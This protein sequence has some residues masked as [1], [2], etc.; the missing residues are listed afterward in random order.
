MRHASFHGDMD[1]LIAGLKVSLNQDE[2]A[3]PAS[4]PLTP[5]TTRNAI[6]TWPAFWLISDVSR[7]GRLGWPPEIDFFEFVNNVDQTNLGGN[8]GIIALKPWHGFGGHLLPAR[9][10]IP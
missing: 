7:T 3:P 8:N 10:A 4:D 2:A 1:R 5:S 9:G 6:G